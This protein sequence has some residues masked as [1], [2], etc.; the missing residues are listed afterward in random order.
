MADYGLKTAL[1]YISWYST[2][3]THRMVQDVLYR[4]QLLLYYW[5]RLLAQQSAIEIIVCDSCIFRG[6]WAS[7]FPID[8]GVLFWVLFWFFLCR[9]SER[10]S[11]MDTHAYS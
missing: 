6:Q 11:Y 4:I 2:E 3:L 1:L 5:T 8:F 10:T 7:T 9:T